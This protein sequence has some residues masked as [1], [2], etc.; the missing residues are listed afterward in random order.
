MKSRLV[1]I[2]ACLTLKDGKTR[3]MEEVLGLLADAYEEKEKE[4]AAAKK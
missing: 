2:A 3:S 1:R 4:Q